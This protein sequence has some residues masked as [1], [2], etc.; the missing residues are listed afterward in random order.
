MVVSDKDDIDILEVCMY[1]IGSYFRVL[2]FSFAF[3]TFY[4]L[5]SFLLFFNVELVFI[6]GFV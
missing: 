1:L 2:P 5:F 3:S 4:F 6:T